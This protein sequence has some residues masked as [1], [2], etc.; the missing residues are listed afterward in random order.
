[1]RF[2]SLRGAWIV[3]FATLGLSFG[4]CGSEDDKKKSNN[5]PHYTSGGEGGS[6][7]GDGP[8]S[9]GGG[10]NDAAGEGNVQGG[11]APGGAGP[12][13]TGPGGAEP[14]G[15]GPGSAGASGD[16][17][18][19]GGGNVVPFQGLYIGEEGDDTAS[20]TID[21]PFATLAHAASVAQAGD[22]IVF[23][24]GAYTL[25]T[26]VTIPAG[27]DVKAQ[28]AGSATVSAS[29]ANARIRLAGD[30]RVTGLELSN[31]Y[32]AIDFAGAAT[33][34]GRLTVEQTKFT[35]CLQVCLSLTGSVQTEVTGAAGVVLS[36]GGQ[37]FAT[38]A[39][40]ASLSIEGG[41]MQNHGAAGI[42]RATDESSVT[43]SALEVLD[44]TG[45]V[46]SLA[47][48]SVGTVTGLTA[49]TLGQGLFEQPNGS[50]STL[51][52]TDSDLSMKPN[53]PA[54]HCFLVYNPSEL[55]ISGSKLHGCKNGLKGGIPA[56][57]TL[58]DTEFYDLEFGGADLD[59][60]GPNVGG[61]VRIAGC[62]FHDVGYVAM[63]MGG[64]ASLLDLKMR[65]TVIDVTTLAN[66][67]GLII[68][69]G[70]ASSLDLGTLAEPGGNT[71]V[72]HTA[73]QNTALGLNT[74][75]LTVQAV[76]NTW[77][78]NQQGADAEGHYVVQ[79]GKVRE[80]ATAV[81]SGINYIK[82]S[83]T[84]TIRLAQIP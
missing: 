29:G 12:G 68:A 62:Q 28:N 4:A 61:V 17:G 48:E 7:A 23:L 66:W 52:V 3:C 71:F 70:N 44:G 2:T 76:G 56:E 64:A 24:D 58:S 19:G 38:L 18:A 35:N 42:I 13:G 34:T 26:T 16:A 5:G 36:N 21:A 15:T 84:T 20:G 32:T 8:A 78:P 50:S 9:K 82:P 22:T 74:Q 43:L 45:L 37:S 51:T 73:T 63:R 11:A 1:M 53:A 60:G 10:T 65:D 83:A 69:A 6:A 33:A 59:T 57:L 27:V 80:D 25:A 41:V 72:Q 14:G 46:L 75:A 47:K 40:T 30:T 79:T 54:N 67:G 55:S 39:Q 31:F 49:S 77:T 81:N